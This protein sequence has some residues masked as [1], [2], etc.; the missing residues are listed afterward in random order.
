MLTIGT[1]L[2]FETLTGTIRM[3]QKA[4]TAYR[5]FVFPEKLILFKNQF[6]TKRLNE[7]VELMSLY[8]S[9]LDQKKRTRL[10]KLTSVCSS[11]PEWQNFEPFIFGPKTTIPTIITL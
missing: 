8:H 4:K 10:K 1:L 7:V 3:R 2:S 6:R 5:W 11:R 9:D